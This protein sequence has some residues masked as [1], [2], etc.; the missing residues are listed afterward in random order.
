MKKIKEK[1]VLAVSIYP[2]VLQT[3]TVI[4][5]IE[6]SICWSKSASLKVAGGCRP[7]STRCKREKAV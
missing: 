3:E 1:L 7:F 2:E 4:T 5:E 6:K